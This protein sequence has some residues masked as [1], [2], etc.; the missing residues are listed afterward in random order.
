MTAGIAWKITHTVPEV[1]TLPSEPEVTLVAPPSTPREKAAAAATAAEP[2]P[3]RPVAS[4]PPAATPGEPPVEM[5]SGVIELRGRK[6]DLPV[7]GA[8]RGELRESFNERR[9]GTRVHE[10][11][12]MLAPRGTPILAVEDGKIVKL[13]VS[14]A[15]GITVYQ[16][17]PTSRFV[18]YYAHL[19]K[20]ANG[21]AEGNK[22]QRG[23]VI[24]YVGTSGNA[25]KDTPHL[26]FAIFQLTEKK[27]W[28]KGTPLDPF[29]ILK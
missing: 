3:S 16:F 1:T 6:L 22:V 26:H 4:P 2:A 13:F 19:D 21:L 11:I 27:E 18:Y 28:W 5:T 8:A 10:A 12:D 24:G 17:D 14:K 20:Y 23:Q 15:G 9:D 29:T 7:Q 25:P